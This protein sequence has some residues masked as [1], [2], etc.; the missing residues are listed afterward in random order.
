MQR[1]Q[2]E[3]KEKKCIFGLASVLMKLNRYDEAYEIYMDLEK[4]FARV[5]DV[6]FLP[7]VKF[8]LGLIHQYKERPNEAL[9]LYEESRY[10]CQQRDHGIEE[11]G[12]LDEK[13]EKEL[14]LSEDYVKVPDLY[15]DSLLFKQGLIWNLN[16]GATDFY[17]AYT[18]YMRGEIANALKWYTLS[19]QYG[20]SHEDR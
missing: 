16:I 18:L 3:D 11:Q 2:D 9:R 13:Y 14:G 17:I 15:D 19:H 12:L 10:D 7:K 4:S 5:D 1:T 8:Y 6:N 20:Q